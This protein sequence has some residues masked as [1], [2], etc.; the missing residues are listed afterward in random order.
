MDTEIYRLT[1]SDTPP[2]LSQVAL[3]D[4]TVVPTT[5][6]EKY[7]ALQR[8]SIAIKMMTFINLVRSALFSPL[9]ELE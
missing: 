4:I 5:E 7:I 6:Y 3:E 8:S 1:G 9:L 2:V